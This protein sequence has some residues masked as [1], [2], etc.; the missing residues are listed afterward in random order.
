MKRYARAAV[1]ALVAGS[2]LAPV[3]SMAKVQDDPAAPLVP[4]SQA[5]PA[6]EAATSPGPAP[7]AV[8]AAAEAAPEE[9]AATTPDADMAAPV[10]AATSADPAALV[11]PAPAENA[12]GADATQ[13]AAEPEVAEPAPASAATAAAA[14]PAA[15]GLEALIA[16][17]AQR[18]GIPV[19]LARAVVRVESNFNPGVTGAAGEV[20]LMQIKPATARGIGYGGSVKAL[21]D[22]DT[23][24]RWGM[25]YLA[26]AY[27]LAGGDICGTIMRYQGGHYATAMNPISTRYCARVKQMMGSA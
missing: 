25:K 27:Q 2:T 8:P 7:D 13:Q 3:H 23:N 15:G 5:E 18:S 10:Q 19:A 12:Q 6:A 14:A 24:L 22:P 17:H 16:A 4:Q 1:A 9:E 21:Y 26:A 20:G 11:I